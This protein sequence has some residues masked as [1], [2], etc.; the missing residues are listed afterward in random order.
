MT[1]KKM[2]KAE[3]RWWNQLHEEKAALAGKF[4]EFWG[5]VFDRIGVERVPGATVENIEGAAHVVVPETKK[6]D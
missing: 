3:V 2:T 6:E 5:D 1:Q 4:A